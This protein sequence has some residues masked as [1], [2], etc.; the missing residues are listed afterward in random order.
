MPTDPNGPQN[1]VLVEALE[2]RADDG[3]LV[4]S[5]DIAAFSAA[6]LIDRDGV[7]QEVAGA[8][9]EQIIAAPA[10]GRVM[11]MGA[12][13]YPGAAG[14]RVDLVVARDGGGGAPAL[15]YVAVI[16]LAAND[17]TVSAGLYLVARS[18]TP[19]WEAGAAMLESLTFLR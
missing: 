1:G 2:R 9:A 19:D 17:F 14:F 7:L 15:P 18:I 11:S 13:E 5:L 3:R 16:A 8:A 4:G 10:E 6:L 12:V